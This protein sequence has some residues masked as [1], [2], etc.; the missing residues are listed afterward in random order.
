MKMNFVW[1]WVALVLAMG[2]ACSGR[3]ETTPVPADVSS[4][5]KHANP[6]TTEHPDAS[7][8]YS[9]DRSAACF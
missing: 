1:V 7:P 5:A 6:S 2:I 9:G 4:T 3:A 8:E